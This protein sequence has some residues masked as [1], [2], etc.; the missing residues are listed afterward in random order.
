M[1][2]REAIR[3][4]V[5]GSALCAADAES[6]FLQIM[7]GGATDAQIAALIVALRMKGETVEEITDRQLL[8]RTM[9]ACPVCDP[10]VRT[11]CPRV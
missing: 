8:F 10:E 1:D 9:C 11:P 2:I 4:T 7:E 3:T 6:V 5:G